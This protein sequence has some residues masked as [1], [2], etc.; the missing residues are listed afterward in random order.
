MF[1]YL[2]YFIDKRGLGYISFKLL[3]CIVINEDDVFRFFV[4]IVVVGLFEEMMIIMMMNL[5]E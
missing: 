2:R 1:D 5:F 3:F 4:M